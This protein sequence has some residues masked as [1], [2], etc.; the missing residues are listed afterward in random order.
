M[1]D[2]SGTKCVAGSTTN[3]GSTA[4]VVKNASHTVPDNWHAAQAR[5]GPPNG[6]SH[7]KQCSRVN[8][9]WLQRYGAI[10]ASDNA[11]EHRRHTL[12]IAGYTRWSGA[13]PTK[14]RG[15]S[16]DAC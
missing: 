11:S 1:P 8:V 10:S 3:S 14:T 4:A 12:P 5:H 7:A 2:L 9:Q 16:N 13:L 6:L 15:P